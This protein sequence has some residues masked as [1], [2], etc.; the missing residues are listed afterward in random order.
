MASV[1]PFHDRG[2]RANQPQPE[3]ARS[4]WCFQFVYASPPTVPHGLKPTSLVASG[5]TAKAVPY[6]KPVRALHQR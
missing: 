2:N 5:G 3:G 6:P 1:H 4:L